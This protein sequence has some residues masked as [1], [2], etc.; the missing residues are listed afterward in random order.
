MNEAFYFLMDTLFTIAL[1]IVM[2]R[3]WLQ[4]VRADFY[5]P[6]SQ[7]VVKATNP[8]IVPLRRIIP[9]IGPLDT[10]SLLLALMVAAAKVVTIQLLLAGQ[11]NPGAT[12]VGALVVF[13]KEAF[14]LLFWVIVIRA[15][16]SWFSQGRNPMEH[17]LHQLTEPLLSP[18]RRFIPPMGGLDLSVVVLL[19]ALQFLQILV[20]NMVSSLF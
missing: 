6:L 18:I 7:F 15:I 20:Q 2:L 3:L 5:N 11:I 19:V 4:L 10:S 12:V 8:L 14:S 9:S 13:I 17:L 16:M 1:M